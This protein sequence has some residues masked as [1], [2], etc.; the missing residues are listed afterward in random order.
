MIDIA[1]KP[2]AEAVKSLMQIS[3]PPFEKFLEH[4]MVLR[5]ECEKAGKLTPERAA[6]FNQYE[7][8]LLGARGEYEDQ[9]AD[10]ICDNFTA[11]EVDALLVFFNGPAFVALQKSQNLAAVVMNIGTVWRT[12]VNER[13]PDFWSMI[14]HDAGEWQQ[15]N[16]PE[17]SEVIVAD[18]PPSASGWKKIEMTPGSA[19]VAEEFVPGAP[20]E[21]A[22]LE[23]MRDTTP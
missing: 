8:A 21:E 15:I 4:T 13:C 9:I 1:S 5:H 16:S 12:R 2:S 6:K 22:E 11:E 19:K 10:L 23:R 20:E 7:A 17:G 14:M 3:M 18:V